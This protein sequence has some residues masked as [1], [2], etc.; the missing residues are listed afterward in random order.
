[1]R[2]FR[3]P[4]RCRWDPALLWDIKQCVV[5]TPYRRFGTIGPILEGREIREGIILD[6]LT[7]ENVAD[8]LS[9]NVRDYTTVRCVIF[10]RAKISELRRFF[11]RYNKYPC[12]FEMCIL[13]IGRVIPAAWNV[14]TVYMVTSWQDREAHSS[15]AIRKLRIRG[16]S[17]TRH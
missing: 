8:R 9:R 5:V 10:R 15:C 7:H 17:S 6:F 4:P 3:L 1:M 13:F 16:A 14:R 2:H 11:T 12:L